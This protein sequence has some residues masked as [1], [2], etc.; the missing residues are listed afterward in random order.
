MTLPLVTWD[1][2]SLWTWNSAGN[3]EALESSRLYPLSTSTE[4]YRCTWP[5]LVFYGSSRNLNSGGHV[6]SES[7]L[8]CRAVF[9]DLIQSL[10]KSI[11]LERNCM[12][13]Q[14]QVCVFRPT[15]KFIFNLPT[16][17]ASQTCPDCLCLEL[18]ICWMFTSERKNLDSHI[19]G[20]PCS[21]FT[22][23]KLGPATEV[24]RRLRWVLVTDMGRYHI[25]I[26][27]GMVQWEEVCLYMKESIY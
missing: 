9:P 19:A 27:K 24:G 2:V 13:F 8:T 5:C 10:K 7:T 21:C 16:M 3:H 17:M 25:F 26:P 1:R 18:P 12:H 20:S 23:T 22:P 4:C 6:C 11:P 15:G 14:E